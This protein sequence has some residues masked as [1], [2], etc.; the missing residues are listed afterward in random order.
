[1]ALD[2]YGIAAANSK[3]ATVMIWNYH[4]E[5]KKG[6]AEPV[7]LNMAGIPATNVRMTH[8]RIDHHNSN[9]YEAWKKMGSPQ[10]PSSAQIAELEKAGQLQVIDK[11]VVNAR[12]GT[13][14]M[15]I[16]LP[17]QGVSLIKLDW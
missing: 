17:R 15:K 7:E 16:S 6:N 4:D 10:D 11:G 5:D 1:M 8:Y 14:V 12:S 2:K 13:V 3:S 9:S